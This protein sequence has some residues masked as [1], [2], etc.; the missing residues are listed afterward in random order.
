MTRPT[1]RHCGHVRRSDCKPTTRSSAQAGRASQTIGGTHTGPAKT[2]A[3][4]KEPLMGQRLRP[5]DEPGPQTSGVV[6]TPAPDAPI[7]DLGR[8][9]RA[10][11]IWGRPVMVESKTRWRPQVLSLRRKPTK[12]N[13]VPANILYI[14][15]GAAQPVR[16]KEL[17]PTVPS[18]T[19]LLPPAQ[20]DTTYTAALQPTQVIPRIIT[21]HYARVPTSQR[22]ARSTTSARDVSGD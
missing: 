11:R 10:R 17:G 13:R 18:A 4:P 2:Y 8:V 15:G 3:G 21:V 9:T 19:P 14:T 5:P 20:S 1:V 22:I 16:F 7:W 12:S 6:P